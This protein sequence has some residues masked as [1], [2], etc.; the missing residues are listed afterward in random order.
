MNLYIVGAT[1]RHARMIGPHLRA[2]DLSEITALTGEDPVRALCRSIAESTEAFT[3]MLDGV[4][5]GLAGYVQTAPNA[6]CVWLLGTPLLVAHRKAFLRGCLREMARVLYKFDIIY[7]WV[8]ESNTL[9]KEWLTWMG[10]RW[11]T[12]ADPM[13]VRG[14]PFRRFEIVYSTGDRRH[15]D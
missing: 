4:P 10:A 3:I 5:C 7:N 6:A 15:R 12:E 9:H 1:E 8:S 13:G 14:E 11:A 2:D